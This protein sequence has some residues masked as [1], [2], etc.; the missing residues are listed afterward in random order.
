MGSPVYSSSPS[1]FAAVSEVLAA[2]MLPISINKGLT[3]AAS[4]VFIKASHI[5]NKT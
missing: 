2:G 5:E 3:V 1:G 4:I